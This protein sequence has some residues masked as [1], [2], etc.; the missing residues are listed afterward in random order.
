M[1]AALEGVAFLL[2]GKLDDMRA[3]GCAPAR[4]RLAGGGTRH[5]AW[6][7]LLAD[8]LAVPLYP[9]GS[10]WLTACGAALIAAAGYRPGDVGAHPG[11]FGRRWRGRGR[12]KPASRSE[13]PSLSFFSVPVIPLTSRYRAVP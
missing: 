6:R 2:R 13:L 1:R 10:G 12:G 4:I 11:P 7:Q 5:P 9:A 8:V 3:A